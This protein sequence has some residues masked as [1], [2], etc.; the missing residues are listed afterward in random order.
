MDK[1]ETSEVGYLL[2]VVVNGVIGM[3]RSGFS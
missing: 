1:P 2:G 3:K